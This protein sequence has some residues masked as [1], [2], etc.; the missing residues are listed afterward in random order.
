M[1]LNRKNVKTLL[2]IIAFAVLL[3]WGLHNTDQAMRI[4]QLALGL[5]LPFLVGGAIAFIL[6]TPMRRIEGLLFPAGKSGAAAARLRRP[7]SILLTLLLVAGIMTVVTF[8]IIP[9]LGRS[10]DTLR[11]GIPAFAARAQQWTAQLSVRW[12]EIAQALQALQVDWNKITQSL[13]SF[14]QAGA[15]SLINSTISIAA[16]IFSVVFTGVLSVVFA[17]YLLAQKEQLAAGAA[18]LLYAWLPTGKAD[19]IVRIARLTNRTFARFLSG[20]FTEA[21]IL[22]LMFFVV[23]SILGFPFA[24]MISVLVG[25]TA[26]IPVFG[27][28]IG[29]FVGIFVIAIQNPIQAVWFLVLFLVL[30][31]VEGNLIYP[32]VVGSSV[33]LPSVWVLVAVT[34]G[35]GMLG[36]VGMLIFIPLCSVI[37]T[38]VK[39]STAARLSDKGMRPAAPG[40]PGQP[41]APPE[42]KDTSSTS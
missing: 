29:C 26:L 18:N 20:Q 14:L 33:G 17:L 10:M 36:V 42:A 22:G 12:P 27:A 39:E 2:G 32:K 1:E 23:M 7:V 3:N 41:L 15:S 16:A 25:I 11:A 30:Q 8:L 34:I 5:L 13:M 6:N 24:L 40:Q 21:F 28:F 31:Q 35:G 37:Y 19:R 4:F 38:L 9:E